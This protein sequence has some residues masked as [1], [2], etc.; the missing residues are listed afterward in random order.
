MVCDSYFPDFYK[1]PYASWMTKPSKNN[2]ADIFYG[3]KNVVPKAPEDLKSPPS[4]GRHFRNAGVVVARDRW[5]NKTTHLQFRSASFYSSTHH[6]RDENCFTLHYKGDLA[7][8]A[9]FYDKYGSEHFRNYFVRTIAHNGIVV[10]DS[11]QKMIYA[12]FTKR[13][14]DSIPA[15]NDGGQTYRL[16][17]YYFKDILPGDM[18]TWISFLIY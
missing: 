2:F 7:I 3:D 17:P 4:L 13:T 16:E 9:G 5:D 10:Y 11:T 15:S 6:H 18:H 12:P 8:D 1:N 14:I